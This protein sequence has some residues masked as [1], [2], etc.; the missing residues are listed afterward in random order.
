M[1]S[2]SAANDVA[3]LMWLNADRTRTSTRPA[4]TKRGQLHLGVRWVRADSLA[5]CSGHLVDKAGQIS[6]ACRDERWR[7]SGHLA[8]ETSQ[9][10][11]TDIAHPTDRVNLA[12]NRLP[13]LRRSAKLPAFPHCVCHGVDHG[14]GPIE[15]HRLLGREVVEHRLL[16]HL[17]HGAIWA[18]SHCRSREPRTSQSRHWRSAGGPAASYVRADFVWVRAFVALCSFEKLEDASYLEMSFCSH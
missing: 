5:K 12:G 18:T 1:A 3:S 10:K 7:S 11:L 8:K 9:V 4:M 14:L 2:F 16:G 6:E 17:G 13:Q 15:E